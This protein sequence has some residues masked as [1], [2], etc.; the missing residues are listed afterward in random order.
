MFT[1]GKSIRIRFGR[2]DTLTGAIIPASAWFIARKL[3]WRSQ[4]S[5]ARGISG[6]AGGRER[7]RGTGV[8]S[9]TPTDGC[10]SS[11]TCLSKAWSRRSASSWC[12]ASAGLGVR[13]LGSRRRNLMRFGEAGKLVGHTSW[14]WRGFNWTLSWSNHVR[15]RIRSC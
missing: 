11:V 15:P 8:P 2:R 10:G 3:F 14:R 6:L 13:T 5:L 7:I 1:G 4:Y 12:L 9:M